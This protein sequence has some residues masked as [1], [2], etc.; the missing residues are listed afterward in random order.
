MTLLKV[1][2][3]LT[4]GAEIQ[5]QGWLRAGQDR[6]VIQ[7]SCKQPLKIFKGIV[8]LSYVDMTFP[9]EEG[10]HWWD[11]GHTITPGYVAR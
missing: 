3:L 5:T 10:C 2:E 8:C 9:G 4:G 6:L 1:T 11:V 7:Q